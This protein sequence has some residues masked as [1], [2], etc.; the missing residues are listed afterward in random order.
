LFYLAIQN[1][2]NAELL[3]A[4]PILSE[5]F[6]GALVAAHS[7]VRGAIIGKVILTDCMKSEWVRDRVGKD[8]LMLGDFSNGRYAWKLSDPEM[9][10]E[11]IPA[12]GFQRIWEHY[13]DER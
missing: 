9:F 1:S 4:H 7:V 10:K 13:I 8:E 6:A 2:T 3:K 12:R 5:G 11:P